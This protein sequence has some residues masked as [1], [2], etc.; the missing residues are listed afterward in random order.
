MC[1][2]WETRRPGACPAVSQALELTSSATA[3]SRPTGR[4]S[5]Q[6][7]GQLPHLVNV[8]F[9][10]KTT[11]QDV[12]LYTDYKLDESYTPTR[13]SVR[14]G[15]NFNDLQEIEVVDISEPSGWIVIP[16]KDINEKLI[17]TFMLQIAILQN[18]QQ[19]RDTH[20]RQI[21]IR[22]PVQDK[23]VSTADLATFHHP[24]F[25]QFQTIR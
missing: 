8:Q 10:K 16:L 22:S 4:C 15:T 9:K 17:R 12:A 20:L 18:H 6:S 13:I 23:P 25:K 3:Q 2:R 19:G 14:V 1:V 24:E 11:V 5:D 21:K 7:D